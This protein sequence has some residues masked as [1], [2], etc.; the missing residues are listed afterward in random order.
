MIRTNKLKTFLRILTL[1]I[2][3]KSTE[4]ANSYSIRQLN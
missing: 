4:E 3:F 2:I 1:Y